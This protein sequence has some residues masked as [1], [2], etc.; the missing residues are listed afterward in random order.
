MLYLILA[1]AVLPSC[2]KEETIDFDGITDPVYGTVTYS[3]GTPAAG[4]QVSDGF[5]VTLTDSNGK[6]SIEERNV[7][8]QW[9][10]YTIPADAMIETG[11]NGLPCFYKRLDRVQRQYD[12][13][14]TRIPVEKKF[15][16]LALGD[17]QVRESNNGIHR[18]NNETA[19]D[20]RE[21]VSSKGGDMP[22][23]AVAMG[24]LVHNEWNLYPEVTE[25]L[26][27]GNLSV[28]CFQVIGNHDHEFMSSDPIPDIRSQR[29]YEAAMGP[30]NYSFDRG[31]VHFLVLDNIVH[32][33]K[34]ESTCTEELCPR[35]MEWAKADL[36]HVPVSKMV[37]VLM[38]AQLTY[39]NATELYELLSAYREA[40]IV[41]AHLH[42]LN[43]LVETVNGKTIHNDD[44]C[45]TNGVDWCA[46]VAGGGEPMGYA[47]YEFSEGTLANQ[48][49]KA[50]GYPEDYQIR[51]Y[52]PDDFPAF[53]YSV[54]GG[55][56]RTYKFGVEGSGYVVAN[57]WNATEDWSFEV[58]EDGVK[59]AS[60]LTQMKMYD[61]WSCWYFYMVLKKNTYSYSRQSGHMF[62][63][64]LV[65]GS[66]SG[67]K[68]V[69]RD[70][71]GN[72]FEQTVFTTREEKDYPA[73]R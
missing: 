68:V 42:Y 70:P 60:S 13:T 26:S 35:V 49:Y 59:A 38:H 37:V 40:R 1:L 65:N 72:R 5:T 18:F 15:R 10:Y 3:D 52:H 28:P 41:S 43:N 29:K 34:N 51:L 25:M 55:T 50:T 2:Q 62:Y 24:D 57:I 14:L 66:A 61:A 71:Y 23:Y 33:G 16:M 64:K 22:T 73:I 46:Q 44:I 67:I 30:V 17:P 58:Y 11:E 6:Y 48:I 32:E 45:T 56:A 21:Y 12:F 53:Q 7:Y 63:H 69:A 20:I 54:Q 47:S 39:G 27:A 8:S 31:D 4:V 19:P 9:V 36:S